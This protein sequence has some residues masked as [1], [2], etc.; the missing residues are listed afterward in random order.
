ML[1]TSVQD[2]EDKILTEHWG[3]ILYVA[4]KDQL[5]HLSVMEQLGKEVG[6]FMRVAVLVVDDAAD[7]TADLKREFKSAKM[8]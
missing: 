5:T 4:Q 1:L 2:I 8:P 3:G 6:D 7:M